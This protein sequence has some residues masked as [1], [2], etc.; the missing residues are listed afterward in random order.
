M[1]GE[2]VQQRA[3]CPGHPG[4]HRQPPGPCRGPPNIPRDH[5]HRQHGREFGQLRGRDRPQPAARAG[6]VQPDE[7]QRETGSR[8]Q[9]GEHTGT[10]RPPRPRP[11]SIFAPVRP[12]S[13][14][15]HA[16][17][18]G[19]CQRDSGQRQGAGPLTEQQSGEHG[20]SSGPDRAQR[21]GYAERR[22]AEPQVQGQHARG[23]AEA[24]PAPPGQ[25]GRRRRVTRRERQ[26]HRH[27]QQA[28]GRGDQGHLDDPGLARG[29]P[30]GEIGAAVAER[31]GQRQH[32]R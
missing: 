20:K 6:P 17:D 19:Q 32:D 1:R 21:S 10:R 28:H 15:G 25:R 13:A 12:D 26:R 7:Q 11:L 29:D 30:G 3:R 24:G 22:L 4:D 9:P 14:R 27:R 2:E 16:E 8:S 18:G 31:G 5:G 23:A